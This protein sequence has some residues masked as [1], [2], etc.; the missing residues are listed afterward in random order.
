MVGVDMDDIC[1][2]DK[3]CNRKAYMDTMIRYASTSIDGYNDNIC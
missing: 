2:D 1:Y 3:T